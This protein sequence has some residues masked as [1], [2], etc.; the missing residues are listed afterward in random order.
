M[1]RDILGRTAKTLLMAAACGL[2]LGL[3]AAQAAPTI[4]VDGGMLE[5][6]AKGGVEQFLGVPFAAPPVGELRWAKP[7]PV[8]SWP[9]T[10]PATAFASKCVQNGW[11]KPIQLYRD[12]DCL[13]LNVYRP[14]APATSPRPVLV[15]FHGGASVAGASQDIDGSVFAEKADHVV[16]GV[17]YRLGAFGL[18]SFAQSGSNFWLMD[19]QAALRWVK[20]NARAFGGDPDHVTII[21]QSAGAYSVAAHMVSPES[22][23]LFHRA[24]AMSL[25]VGPLHAALSAEEERQKG[26]TAR[27]V[28][29]AGCSSAADVLACMRGK[30]TEEVFEA[31]G[32]AAT[33]AAGW[34]MVVD[35]QTIPDTPMKLFGRG[36]FHKVPVLVGFASE[37]QGFFLQARR[38]SGQPPLSADAL[39]KTIA[40]RP[41]GARIAE[42]YNV[43]TYGS[44]T[45]TD[46]ALTSDRWGCDVRQWIKV[47]SS[48]IP[49]FSYE[50]ADPKA[51]TT[52]FH[53]DEP[54]DGPFHNSDIPYVFQ[55][56]YPN[57]QQAD[58]PAW[59][60][61]QKTLS[62][63]M[64]GY[65]ASFSRSSVP[66]ADW[67]KVETMILHP[68]GDRAEAD[69]AFVK[70]HSCEVWER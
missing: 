54:V 28:E 3:S 33:R 56:G 19:Q 37:E 25:P 14:A 7:A 4:S 40:S 16:I 23:G 61:A 24:I 32:G 64:L 36:E 11:V 18:A 20:A 2:S 43:A 57:E 42:I 44:P 31:G 35:K 69:A 48:A 15:W 67:P 21:G 29:K 47:V 38:A 60:P 55:R 68:E 26:P 17:N 65:V 5:G 45:R 34:Q 66:S 12:E 70:R 10:R 6:V 58:A 62:D 1:E 63:R 49:V 9:G 22:A 51:P 13:Y 50:F 53:V 59:T 8:K 39:A 46:I 27:M 52:I 30:S 41:N